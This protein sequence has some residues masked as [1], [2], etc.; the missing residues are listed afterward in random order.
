MA[1][2]R[3]ISVEGGEGAGKSTNIE[4]VR[5]R[6]HAAGLRVV[7]TREPGG[8]PLAEEIR[9]L[10]LAPRDEGVCEDTELL[11]VFAARMQHVERVIK[12]ALARGDWVIS[13][14]F[15]DATIAYQGAGRRMGVERIQA[16]RRLL[17]GDFAPD[18]T[19]LLDVPV[20]SGM[21]RLAG[22]G[23][24]DRFE[25]EGREFFERVRAA[26]LQ[27][28]AAEPAR[29]RVI[30]AAQELPAVQA[31]VAQAVEGFLAQGTTP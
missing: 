12:P 30:D 23:A 26:Y 22:R 18:L 19:L 8:T 10:L 6:L 4:G 14:R 13:D 17:L 25:M 11:L 1:R 28:A 3:F 31:A 2:G 16:L 20:D 27:L 7:V 5:A 9:Q 24:P 29:F 21:Q 15:T